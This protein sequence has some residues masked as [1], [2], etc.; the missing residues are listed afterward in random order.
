[1]T[2]RRLALFLALIIAVPLFSTAPALA[3]YEAIVQRVRGSVVLIGVNT[4]RGFA[5]G[6][7]FLISGDGYIVTARHVI[8]DATKITVLTLDGR[9]AQG[10]VIRYSDIFD[11]AVIKIDGLGFSFLNF[12]DSDGVQQG[13][14]ILVF[15]YPFSNVLGRDTVTV[16]R[17]I[18]SAVRPGQGL[19][20]IDAALNPGNSGGP[21]VNLRGEVIGVAVARLRGGE[22][23]NF[24]VAGNLARS[25]TNQLTPTP[26]ASPPASN[27]GTPS[28]PTPPGVPAD[29]RHP[30]WPVEMRARWEYQAN[31]SPTGKSGRRIR[32][33]T[34]VE[35]IS[36]RIN[37]TES[38]YDWNGVASA[39]SFITS[40]GI[41]QDAITRPEKGL[42][43]TLPF[44]NLIVPFN[45]VE[46]MSWRTGQI[47]E[48]GNRTDV[49][50]ETR[51][52]ARASMP[53]TTPAGSFSNCVQVLGT[54]ESAVTQGGQSGRF[55]FLTERIY[56]S[57][58][59]WVYYRIREVNGAYSYEISLVTF[60][61]P[62]PPT[63]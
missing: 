42:R 9:E 28:P 31:E 3:Q 52:I 48:V 24:A 26:I 45:P 6:S 4:P 23:V 32:E 37:F 33:V 41:F 1:M 20:Q 34:S 21:V 51:R 13:Q 53:Y 57:G 17:G 49:F 58:V 55:L 10:S 44:P 2:G 63:P 47:S 14:E 30:Y 7:G 18:V 56:C 16:T 62:P 12:G 11:A 5:S 50:V 35:R 40:Q 8:E 19:I 60:L 43:V 54:A 25:L 59:G 22:A 39:R 29:L 61:I 38:D 27:V 15:G 46:G 36:A